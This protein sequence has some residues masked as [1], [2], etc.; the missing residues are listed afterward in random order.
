[1]I[2]R[3]LRCAGMM[4][5][6]SSTNCRTVVEIIGKETR[7]FFNRLNRV[8]RTS[9]ARMN[10]SGE[11]GSPCR[12]PH[13]WWKEEPFRLFILRKEVDE[14]KRFPIYAIH[15]GGKPLMRRTSNR[16]SQEMLSKAFWKSTFRKIDGILF[17]DRWCSISRVVRNVCMRCR[18]LVKAV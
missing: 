11:R 15:S 9:V 1:M 18:P 12:N 14:I 8:C 6:M 3:F 16:K 13:L 7:S 2:L 17:L 4:M 10:N 5:V